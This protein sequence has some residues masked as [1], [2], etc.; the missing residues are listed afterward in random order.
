MVSPWIEAAGYAGGFAKVQK[1]FDVWGFWAMFV[2]GFSPV[3]FKL[4]TIGAGVVSMPFLPFLLGSAIGRGAR[5]FLVAGLMQWG[6]ERMERTLHEYIDRLGW[7]IILIGVVA[8]LV[9]SVQR[10]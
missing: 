10:G 6:G 9:V 8:F 4:F 5:F 1:W 7:V 2:A 3:P